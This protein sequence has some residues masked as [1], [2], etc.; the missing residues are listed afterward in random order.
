MLPSFC[1]QDI[2][3]MSGGKVPGS[4][5]IA[6]AEMT[7]LGRMACLH[8]SDSVGTLARRLGVYN[9]ISLALSRLAVVLRRP[10]KGLLILLNVQRSGR[11]QHYCLDKDI[12]GNST[13]VGTVFGTRLACF[14]PL[15]LD[16]ADDVQPAPHGCL[17]VRDRVE[18]EV[19]IH[20]CFGGVCSLWVWVPQLELSL[21]LGVSENTTTVL[22]IGCEV[23]WIGVYLPS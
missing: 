12:P 16:V 7:S 11:P 14:L 4:I 17:L 19:D 15:R 23:Y 6:R 21:L 3:E 18:H 20:H 2:Q 8:R 5:S 13:S 22:M 1:P 9:H 10:R